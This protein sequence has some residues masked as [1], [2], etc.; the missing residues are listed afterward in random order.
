[1]KCYCF[2]RVGDTAEKGVK[3]KKIQARREREKK[4][5]TM[6]SQDIS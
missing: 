4:G 2:S 5:V 1:M 6:L 3:V